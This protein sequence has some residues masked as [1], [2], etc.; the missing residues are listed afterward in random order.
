M[1]SAGTEWDTADVLTKARLNQ[2]NVFV[3][4]GSQ[5][6][7]VTPTFAG[8]HAYCITSGSGFIAGEEYK[9][10]STNTVWKSASSVTGE[11]KFGGWALASI[12]LGYLLC[13]GSAVSRSTYAELFTAVSTRFGVGNGS[14]TFNL[15]DLRSVFP[16]GS[17]AATEAGGT[18]GS[19]TVTLTG[20][21]SGTSVHGHN[22]TDPGHTHGMAGSGSGGSVGPTSGNAGTAYNTTSNTTGLSVNNSSAADAAAAHE[23]KP[24]FQNFV[25]IIA[26]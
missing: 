2:K 9:R 21:E 6:N 8:Q 16:R 5:I 19:S 23:N 22:V 11:I 25:G 15:P 4:T 24:P 14:T 3:G 20:A 17:P 18:G 1:G 12:P 10:D 7:A 26:Y 13:D